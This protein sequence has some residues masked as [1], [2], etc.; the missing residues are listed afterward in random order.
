MM[1]NNKRVNLS[2]CN[3]MFQRATE[4]NL[5]SLIETV[6]VLLSIWPIEEHDNFRRNKPYNFKFYTY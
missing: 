4:Q 5:S 3:K 2:E 1:P 6:S